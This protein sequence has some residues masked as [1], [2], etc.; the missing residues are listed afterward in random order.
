MASESRE[1]MEALGD[2]TRFSIVE[3]V[4]RKAMTGDE[5]AESVK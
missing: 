4:S 1:I 2:K 3:S 5:I